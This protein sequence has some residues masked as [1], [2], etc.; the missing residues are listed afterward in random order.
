MLMKGGI[1][2]VDHG[3]KTFKKVFLILSIL[4]IVGWYW[5]LFVKDDGFVFR[6]KLKVN[7]EQIL[8]EKY[9]EEFEVVSSERMS[10]SARVTDGIIYKV[11]SIEHPDIV[12]NFYSYQQYDTV[13]SFITGRSNYTT[14]N[15]IIELL[16]RDIANFASENNFEAERRETSINFEYEPYYDYVDLIFNFSDQNKDELATK[17]NA[18]L[19]ITQERYSDISGE[20]PFSSGV[21][22]CFRPVNGDDAMVNPCRRDVQLSLFNSGYNS[23]VTSLNELDFS[24][25]AIHSKF[26]AYEEALIREVERQKA[27]SN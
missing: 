26:K 24:K 21:S 23:D 7:V 6:D 9:N 25:E 10:K 3:S 8:N 15:Y 13:G 22:V 2:Y 5:I 11:K 27:L 14:D 18:F 4:S 1:G 17:L 16:S 12:F 20:Q 19:K